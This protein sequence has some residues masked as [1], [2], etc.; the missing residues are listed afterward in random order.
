MEGGGQG[1]ERGLERTGNRWGVKDED[2]EWEKEGSEKMVS[3]GD[4]DG[5]FYKKLW[6]PV[7]ISGDR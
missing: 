7:K 5:N 6:K 2:N 1:W 4:A 3:G